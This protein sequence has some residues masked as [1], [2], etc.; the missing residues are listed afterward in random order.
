MKFQMCMTFLQNLSNEDS[1]AKEH[2]I[3]CL[4]DDC[5]ASISAFK[6]NDYYENKDIKTMVTGL[7]R[8]LN[9]R[10]F[11]DKEVFLKDAGIRR[12]M[13]DRTKDL[14]KRDPARISDRD[15]RYLNR[16]LLSC[17]FPAG[18]GYY[19]WNL[20]SSSKNFRESQAKVDEAKEGVSR[21]EEFTMKLQLADTLAPYLDMTKEH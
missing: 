15:L 18:V 14:L 19:R 9:N 4:D 8:L 12:Y 5:R 13:D 2:L 3:K 6:T 11:P 16:S 10:K 17:I 21:K 1:P 20:D 7:N